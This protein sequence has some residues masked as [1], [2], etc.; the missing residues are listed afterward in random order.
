M[1]KQIEDPRLLEGLLA[2]AKF[3][4]CCCTLFEFFHPLDELTTCNNFLGFHLTFYWGHLRSIA[5]SR[6]P[7]T[8]YV[9]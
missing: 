6:F 5:R 4:F 9:A 3:T 8:V 1:A 7:Q 2:P